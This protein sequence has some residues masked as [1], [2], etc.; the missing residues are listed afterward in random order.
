MAADATTTAKVKKAIK[1]GG[2]GLG[3]VPYSFFED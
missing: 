2:K 1:K 3:E